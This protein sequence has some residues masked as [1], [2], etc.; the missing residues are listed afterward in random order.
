MSG[1]AGKETAPSAQG[2][3]PG[4]QPSGQREHK[5]IPQCIARTSPGLLN[6][7]KS[8]QASPETMAVRKDSKVKEFWF[9]LALRFDIHQTIQTFYDLSP[10]PD[11]N[12]RFTTASYYLT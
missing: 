5:P 2:G 11:P 8:L 3:Q 7:V 12:S 1:P 10:S 6:L 9:T 4:P